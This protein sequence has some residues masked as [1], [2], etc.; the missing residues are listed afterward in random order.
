MH[1]L[2]ALH[3]SSWR[4]CACAD[5]ETHVWLRVGGGQTEEGDI[6]FAFFPR[7]APVTVAHILKLARMGCY[8]SNHFFRVSP[9]STR[10]RLLS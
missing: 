9:C 6:E 2:R 10:G 3:C 4:G 7:V 5:A 8:T 1:G